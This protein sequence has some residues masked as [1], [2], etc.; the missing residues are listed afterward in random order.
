MGEVEYNQQPQK[1]LKLDQNWSDVTVGLSLSKGHRVMQTGSI[2][3][4]QDVCSWELCSCTSFS[5]D[6][7]WGHVFE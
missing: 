5:S 3:I 1:Q 4:G 2:W 6:G 7:A